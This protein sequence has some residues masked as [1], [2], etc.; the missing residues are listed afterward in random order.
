MSATDDRRFEVLRAIVTDYV[1]TQEPIGSKA[2]VERH[3]LGVS[4][5][6]V[7]NDM[8]VLEAE[9]YIAQPHTSSGRVP[10][11]KGY[12]M[13]VDRISEVKPLSAAERRAILSVLDRGVDLDDVLRRSVRLLAQLTRQVAVIQYPVLSTATVRHLEVV[14]LSPSRLLL[15]VITDT[16]RVEQRMV[17]LGADRS[18]DDISRLRD[19]FSAALHGKRLEEA[20]AAVAELA[21]EA[22][23]D[24][25]DEVI[26]LATVLVETLVERGVDR[27]VLGGTSNL[28]RSAADFAPMNGGMDTVLEA[29]EE[30]VVVLKLLA[31]TQRMGRVTVQIGEETQTENLRGTS[32]V[33]TGYGASGTIFGS[34]GVVG[35]TRM[36][37]PGT[38]ASVAA[39]AKYVGEVLAER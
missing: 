11:D 4:S 31:T 33:S 10:T 13:F 25:R 3:H 2:L 14:T 22:P 1:D 27:L 28:A 38:I 19:M 16:G 18:E 7:R 35:P 20:S 36:D 9:G 39:V 8:A 15:V 32:V 24:I 37:Y 30:Q 12:R 5:A 26:R 17:A 29:L 34:V 21:N 6:T 23:G